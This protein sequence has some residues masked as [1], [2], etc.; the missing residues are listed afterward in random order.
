[1][2]WAWLEPVTWSGQHDSLDISSFSLFCLGRMWKKKE[3]RVYV[4][5]FV[6]E[7]RNRAESEQEKWERMDGWENG[8]VKMKVRER[9]V[10][11][12]SKQNER[13]KRKRE[14][15]NRIV[16][17]TRRRERSL[18]WIHFYSSH[19]PL[20]LEVTRNDLIPLCLILPFEWLL[21]MS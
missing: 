2:S 3:N 13:G 20:L 16:M 11:R 18:N 1:M 9:K 14:G 21:F 12:E 8:T 15:R 6:D 4:T 10:K 17:I 5:L 19:L 7:K